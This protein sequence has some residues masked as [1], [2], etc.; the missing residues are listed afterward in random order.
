MVGSLVR[1]VVF[2]L[3]QAGEQLSRIHLDE[4]FD[5]GPFLPEE[6]FFLR[7]P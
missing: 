2:A 7:H 3:R 5:V 4:D 6:L 1:D